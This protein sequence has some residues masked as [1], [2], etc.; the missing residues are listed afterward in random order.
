MKRVL[1]IVVAYV[2]LAYAP[3]EAQRLGTPYRSLAGDTGDRLCFNWNTHDPAIPVTT[4]S[5][6]LEAM[7]H[8]WVYGFV[9]GAAYMSQDRLPRIN[10][11]S[12]SDWMDD[13][14][15]KHPRARIVDGAAALIEHLATRR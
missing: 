2:V 7:P 3:G 9:S 13:Y 14:C 6:A 10:A 5:Y 8:A 4:A 1:S 11:V 12:T 15:K